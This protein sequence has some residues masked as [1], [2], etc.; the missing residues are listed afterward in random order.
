VI[1]GQNSLLEVVS[2]LSGSYLLE[3][4]VHNI[5]MT[6]YSSVVAITGGSIRAWHC[7]GMYYTLLFC[8]TFVMPHLLADGGYTVTYVERSC[9]TIT[10]NLFLS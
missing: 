8:G 2:Y 4:S 3:L 1:C 9:Y 10:R 7:V 5:F 6:D